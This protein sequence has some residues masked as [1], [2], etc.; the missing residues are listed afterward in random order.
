MAERKPDA[1]RQA[2]I[3]AARSFYMSPFPAGLKLL[4]DLIN[5]RGVEQWGRD[6]WRPVRVTQIPPGV[7][8]PNPPITGLP[9]VEPDTDE[10]AWRTPAR[11][12]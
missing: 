11:E 1:K 3:T 7:L 8:P 10:V 9:P 12:R 6:D 2:F 5:A 4:V